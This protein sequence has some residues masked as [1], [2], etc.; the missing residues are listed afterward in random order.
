MFFEVNSNFHGAARVGVTYRCTRGVRNDERKH[1]FF[2]LYLFLS[3]RAIDGVKMDASSLNNVTAVA[4]QTLGKIYGFIYEQ[5][6][7]ANIQLLPP[8]RVYENLSKIGRN[9]Y[10]YAPP[11]L[12]QYYTAVTQFP[13][14]SNILT[15]AILL[16]VA[17]IIFS[18][19]VATLRS[20]ARMIYGFVRFTFF[21]AVIA[22]IIA[23]LQQQLNISLFDAAFSWMQSM[24][25]QQTNHQQTMYGQQ[26][27]AFG[28]A[29][30][31]QR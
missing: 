1:L 5:L 12:R 19:V 27:A 7:H 22:T 30:T 4:F 9:A 23:V 2:F 16:V 17:Y 24:Q 25:E 31:R 6:Q 21:I 15:V 26:Q 20:I 18:I 11:A 29:Y 13:L 28:N 8:D 14:Q 10:E 3:R